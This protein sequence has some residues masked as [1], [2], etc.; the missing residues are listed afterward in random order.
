MPEA[1]VRGVRHALGVRPVYKTVDT[2]AAEFAARTPYHY[3]SYDEETEVAPRER[4]AVIIL[5]SGPNRIGQG[6]EFDYSCVHASFALREAGFETVMVNC[7]PETV[8]TDYD[9]SE[10]ALLRAAHARGR[11]RGRPRRA[12]RPGPVAGVIVQLGG[13]TPLGLAQGA[14]GRRRADRRHVSPEAIHLAED[15]GAFGRVLAEAGLPA[16]KHGTATVVRGGGRGRRARSATRCSSGPSYVLG[17]RGMEI[18]YDDDDARATTSTRATAGRRPSTRCWSTGSSTTPSRS[19]STRCTTATSSTSAASWSTSRRPASTPATRPA[20]CRRSPSA[21]RSRAGSARPP[22]RR[23]RASASRG[24]L[25]VQF[26][27][28]AGRPLRAGGQPARVAHRAVRGQGDRRA[29]GQGRG[30]GHARRHHRRAARRGHAA[31]AGRRRHAAGARA[32][33]GQGGGAAVQA[34]PHPRGPVVDT[35]LGPEM[36]STGEVMGIDTDFGTAFAKSQLRPYG[37]LPTQGHGLRLRRQPRQAGD[38]LPGQAAGRPRL[39][40]PA[41]EGTA[42]VLR[43]NGVDATVVRKHSEGPG[44]TASRPSS[45]ASWPA[46]STWSSTR[47]RV[48]RPR[49]TATRSARRRPAWTGRSSPRC[50]SSAPPC[51]ASRR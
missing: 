31:G 29:A 15:R 32:G 37:G 45:T 41:T 46:R 17:G 34:V 5:G 43:R 9:T 28:A 24:L 1:V 6:I 36:R 22:R 30:P 18:V 39:R 8:S 38:D 2:C 23:A 13:Q 49:P 50:S 14:Q 26:A 40:D 51:R 35:V 10:P 21:A 44:P 16:P 48:G 19:T 33:R 20:R 42:E 12:R 47:R 3:C 4:P 25:N 27:L 11:A 7:N